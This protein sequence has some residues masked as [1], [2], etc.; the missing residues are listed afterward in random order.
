LL[1]NRNAFGHALITDIAGNA[2]D[3]PVPSENP[4]AM[5]VNIAS[6]AAT[7]RMSGSSR[8]ANLAAIRDRPRPRMASPRRRVS[9]LTYA[10]HPG[11]R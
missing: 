11:E 2:S 4:K 5:I 8:K 3:K 9:K 1:Q 6:R 7:S 10:H